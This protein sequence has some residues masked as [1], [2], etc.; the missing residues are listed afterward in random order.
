MG[1]ETGISWTDSTWN[2]IR[3]CS[4]V[5]EGCRHCYAESVAHRFSGPG[6]PYEGLV[7]L[8][9]NGKSTGKWNGVIKFVENHLL[10]PLK[11]KDSRRIFVNSMSDLF[12][13]NV[14]D[15]IRDK[16][17]AVIRLS[18]QH[19]LQILTKREDN[20]LRYMSDKDT[21]DRIN[22][23]L[24]FMTDDM[25]IQRHLKDAGGVWCEP[26]RG[27][28][29]RIE[30]AGYWDNLD[31]VWPPPNAH[32][33]VSV[34]DQK[35]ADQRIPKLLD[36]PAAIRFISAEPL[37]G[38]IEPHRLAH[39]DESNLNAFKGQI[40]HLVQS[41]AVKPTPCNKLDWVIIGGESGRDARPFEL[42]WAES[43]IK[44]CKEANVPVFMKQLGSN[45]KFS[46]CR[47]I[48]EDKSGADPS[49]WPSALKVQEFPTSK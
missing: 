15:E 48:T 44:K 19:T 22:E 14:T 35:T 11:W 38:P 32:L 28:Y 12:H 33:G 3:G 45:P 34:E 31:V 25:G 37:L 30:L 46:G 18:P 20:M 43:L 10:D 9:A 24:A 47:F 13:E 5:S 17:F 4:R 6:L 29:G 26:Q 41:Q 39:G 21:P 7:Q 8:G 1:K 2:P 36:T 23:Y 40:E 27:E 49:E 42:H 16:I